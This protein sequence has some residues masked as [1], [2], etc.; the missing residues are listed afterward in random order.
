MDTSLPQKNN[1][2]QDV[3]YVILVRDFLVKVS[4][5]PDAKLRDIVRFKNGSL[6]QV[7]TVL[8]DS[9]DVLI[10]EDGKIS[11]GEEVYLE[12]K[13]ISVNIPQ[14]LGG[15]ILDSLGHIR[16]QKQVSQGGVSLPI[17]KE[18]M[19]IFGRSTITKTFETGVSIVDVTVPL[20]SGQR[21]LVV[22]DR[23]TGKTQFLFQVLTHQAQRGLFCIYCTVGKRELEI[24][25]LAQY[26]KN[27]KIEKNVCIVASSISD[28]LGKIFL[29][30]YAAMTI[31]EHIRDQGQS[32]LLILDD[33]TSHAQFYREISLSAKRF[34][35]RSAYPGNIFHLHSSLMERA[36]NFK[37]E[38]GEASITC[39][40]VAQSTFGDIAGYITTNLMSMTDGHIYLDTE[41]FDQGRR[42]AVNPFLSVTR[43]GHQTQT[44]LIRDISREITSLLIEYKQAQDF[45]HF[46]SEASENV[47]HVLAKGNI[48]YSLF[49][50]QPGK[51]V[52][53]LL[54]FFFLGH[55]LAGSF[56]GQTPEAIRQ[57]LYKKVDQY[58]SNET[59]RSSIIQIMS[60]N[61]SIKSFIDEIGKYP[62]N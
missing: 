16:G 18:P 12:G 10:I 40:P 25:E 38:K 15:V 58:I 8:E 11:I 20:G 5:L 19:N 21:E 44:T 3:G 33:L 61:M 23:K 45:S 55:L 4:G 27:T 57:L 59:Y 32:V 50:Q 31:A 26:I 2:I 13:E 14:T 51:V 62:L 48:V 17:F 41:L 30:P 43:V 49:D 24:L 54:V 28:G 39:L 22:G 35:G 53:P 9:V 42:P 56:K 29:T 52:P 1:P 6:G 47:K 37:N 46:G 36:G 60:Q 34:P 7:F